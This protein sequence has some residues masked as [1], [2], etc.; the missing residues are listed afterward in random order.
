[1]SDGGEGP[2]N[3]KDRPRSLSRR[4]SKSAQQFTDVC[5]PYARA[6]PCWSNRTPCRRERFPTNHPQG[7]TAPPPLFPAVVRATLCDIQI[8]PRPLTRC[9]GFFVC[10]VHHPAEVPAP[11]P[12]STPDRNV[13][14]SAYLSAVSEPAS[15]VRMAWTAIAAMTPVRKS[16]QTPI[17]IAS[18]RASACR[19]TI[20]P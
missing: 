2:R 17:P 6:N 18:A 3:L 1:L 16:P 14:P 12:P 5:E 9:G 7:L 19:G 15:A 13:G 4:S 11:L 10:M 20:S 8:E